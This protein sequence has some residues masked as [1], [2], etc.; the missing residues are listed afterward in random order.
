MGFFQNGHFVMLIRS[1]KNIFW[2][3]NRA[4]LV[5]HTLVIVKSLFTK[6]F[7]VDSHF[8]KIRLV[9]LYLTINVSI[10]PNLAISW[11][12]FQIVYNVLIIFHFNI[13]I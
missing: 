12:W 9:Y 11:L 4:N 10:C 7:L 1:S 5:Q 8:L 2:G 3:R 6:K 13:L